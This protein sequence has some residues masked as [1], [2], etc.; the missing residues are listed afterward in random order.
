M[1]SKTKNAGL[2]WYVCRDSFGGSVKVYP[3]FTGLKKYKGCCFYVSGLYNNTGEGDELSPKGGYCMELTASQCKKVFGDF[4][5]KG[6]AWLVYE[7][8]NYIIWEYMD[9]PFANSDSNY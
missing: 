8:G 3:E 2:C 1:A 7:R 9:I 5:Q 6:E 4:P